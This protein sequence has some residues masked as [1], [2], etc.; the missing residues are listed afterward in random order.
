MMKLAT[1]ACGRGNSPP[2]RNFSSS[3][4]FTQLQI[5]AGVVS[6]VGLVDGCGCADFSVNAGVSLS[7]SLQGFACGLFG[8][9]RSCPTP[10]GIP[11][12]VARVCQPSDSSFYQ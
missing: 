5:L 10:E 8:V 3:K 4:A 6:L 2:G 11:A 7:K 1:V 12:S 9:Q